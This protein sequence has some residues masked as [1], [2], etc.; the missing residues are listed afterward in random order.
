MNPFAKGARVQLS[1]KGISA[2]LYPRSKSDRVGIIVGFS[3]PPDDC[4]WV[5]W[6][7]ANSRHSIHV[8]FIK[9]AILSL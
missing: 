6:D 4:V 3:R 7:G 2:N 8:S 9:S 1:E 5:T